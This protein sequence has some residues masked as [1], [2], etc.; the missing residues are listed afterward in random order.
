MKKVIF[1]A[2]LMI[3]TIWA[4]HADLSDSLF[5]K[6]NKEQ[7]VISLK[8]TEWYYLCQDTISSLEHLII[9]TAMDLDKIDQYISKHRNLW[10]RV[11]LKHEKTALIDQLQKARE[12]IV[13]NMKKFENNLIKKYVQYFL[14]KITPYKK[15]LQKSV[16]KIEILNMSGYATRELNNYL[17]LLTWQLTTIDA[18]GK[19][20]T[21]EELL[22]LL[23]TYVY[24]KKE[25]IWSYE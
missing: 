22:P 24:F 2:L 17:Y 1:G 21:M 19:A 6:V 15:Q 11:W 18:L 20:K 13:S 10:Y 25:I 12:S 4:V 8:Q 16:A 7:V 23:S 3:V 5:C 9:Q 14:L